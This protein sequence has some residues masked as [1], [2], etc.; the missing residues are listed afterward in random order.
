MLVR[1]LGIIA[2]GVAL[3]IGGGCPAHSEPVSV[4]CVDPKQPRPYFVTFDFTTKRLV[5]ES[6]MWNIAPGE[7]TFTNDDR[8]ELAIKLRPGKADAVFYP[9]RNQMIW[10]GFPADEIRPTLS[11]AC[12]PVSPRTVLI[13]YDNLDPTKSNLGEPNKPY[14][15]SCTD[16]GQPYF[17]TLDQQTKKVVMEGVAGGVL[18]SGKIENVSGP[19]TAFSVSSGPTA[20][21]LIWDDRA[22]QL[23]WQGIAT[24]RSRPTKVNQCTKVKARSILDIYNALA[25]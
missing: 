8:A 2:L 20:F 9:H 5:F 24:D 16:M 7:I 15:L 25:R 3:L 13:M 21:A 14:S 11:H 23:T 19:Q 12:T 10:P 22:G 6:T 4:R 17:L 18:F 1:T